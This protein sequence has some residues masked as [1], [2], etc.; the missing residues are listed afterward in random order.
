M[1]SPSAVSC[2]AWASPPPSST[3]AP[4][5]RWRPRSRPS[6]TR[7]P[8]PTGPLIY[9]AGTGIEVD[10]VNYMIPIEADDRRALS[11]TREYPQMR[12][13]TAFEAVKGAKRLRLV[14]A[15]AC[16]IDPAVVLGAPACVTKAQSFKVIEPPRGVLVAYSTARRSVCAG[17]DGRAQPLRAGA[18]RGLARARHRARQG[19]P[20]RQ[21]QRRGR[22]QGRAGADRD[23]QLAGRGPVRVAEVAATR[24]A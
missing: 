15:D 16:R 20:P 18:D 19:V 4:A 5:S 24:S 2:A 21:R 17:R 10:G 12:L 3:T 8:A 9:Y 7:P 13:D 6:G 11:F 22:D 23:R 14:I 1:S